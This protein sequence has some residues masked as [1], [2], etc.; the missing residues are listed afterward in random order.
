MDFAV[1]DHVYVPGAGVGRVSSIE[2]F[3]LDGAVLPV[4]V[5]VILGSQLTYR[6]PRESLEHNQV[7]PLID[8]AGIEAVLDLLGQPAPARKDTP[9]AAT[10]NRRYREYGKVIQTGEPAGIAGILRELLLLKR[11]K[12]LSFGESRI[13]DQVRNL[14]AQ[15]IAVVR[16]A[17]IESVITELEELVA[18]A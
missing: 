5:I 9:K 16:E 15:E 6:I 3:E 10:W 12:S 14:I 17:E 8:K 2:D 11:H 13:L 4:L 7:R 18:K 1:D